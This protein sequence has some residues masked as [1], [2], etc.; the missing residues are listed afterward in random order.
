MHHLRNFYYPTLIVVMLLIL[1]ACGGR[2]ADPTVTPI[3]SPT[4]TES[5]ITTPTE[6]PPLPTATP[7]PTPVTPT[8]TP[9]PPT[10]ASVSQ[11]GLPLPTERGAFFSASGVC[12]SCHTN[13]VDEAGTDVSIDAFWRASMMANAARDPYWQASVRAET[14]NLPGYRAIIEDKCAS[15]HMPMARFTSMTSGGDKGKMFDDGFLNP[16]NELHTLAM[17]GVSCTLCHQIEAGNL[18]E[19]DSFSGHFTFNHDLPDGG[20]VAYGAHEVNEAESQ[21]M[22]A[23]SGFIP[24]QGLHIQQSELC[25]TCHTLYTPYIDAATG[26]IAGEFP[27]QTPY[28][29]WLSSD[30]RDSQACQDCHMPKAQGGVRLSI[31]G[32]PARTPFSQHAFTFSN[33]YMLGLLKTFGGELEV[34]AS[35]EQFQAGIERA[36]G[37]LNNATASVTL[38]DVH[39]S[40]SQLVANAV[41]ESQVGHKFPTGFPS[42]RAWLHVTVRD[43][44]SK[45]IFESG[46][47]NPDGSVVGND[48]DADPATYE[49]HYKTISDPGQVQIYE[50]IMG[51]TEDQVTTHLLLAANYL[52]DNRLLPLGFDKSAIQ[53]DIAAYGQALEDEDFIGGGDRI[54]YIVDVTDADG[55]YTVTVELL[56]Q[57]IAFRWA[58]NLDAYEAGEITRFL[59]YY[60]AISNT[61]VTIAN[62]TVEVEE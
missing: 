23:V 50:A 36:L 49:P 51:D 31:T 11:P 57:T 3:P 56:Y 35:S 22:Q 24:T 46:G 26:E 54:Q 60:D 5:K 38:E 16:E 10:P 52:K 19:Q 32:G 53:E 42:R 13:M 21:L 45:V 41:I 29:E 43:A 48:N 55:P 15:C 2:R 14:L 17:D 7:Q 20:R 6:T 61:P 44:N 58:Q 28:L 9:S 40:E 25:A 39:L 12:A 18:G 47:F 62:A 1:A 27:E 37:Q 59:R 30:Y 8:D 4:S 34:T 33:A